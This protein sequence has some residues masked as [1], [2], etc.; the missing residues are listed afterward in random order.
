VIK[1][2]IDG[3]WK[4]LMISRY[5]SNADKNWIEANEKEISEWNTSELNRKI[6][7]AWTDELNV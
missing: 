4:K 7:L 2:K 3:P 6:Y 5:K 1:T